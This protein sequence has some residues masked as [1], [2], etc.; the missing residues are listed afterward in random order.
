MFTKVYGTDNNISYMNKVK[1]I[2]TTI[3]ILII[4][5]LVC[6]LPAVAFSFGDWPTKSENSSYKTNAIFASM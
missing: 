5:Y 6:L 4:A 1:S 3:G 2:S